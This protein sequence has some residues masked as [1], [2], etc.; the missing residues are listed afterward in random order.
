MSKINTLVSIIV[1]GALATAG[2]A[3]AETSIPTEREALVKEATQLCKNEF[4][5]WTFGDTQ[6]RIQDCVEAV[7]DANG[8]KGDANFAAN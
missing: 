2:S 1:F 4:H 8:Q 3:M 6:N 7:L 5:L